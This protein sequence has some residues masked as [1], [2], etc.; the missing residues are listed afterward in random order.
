M[1]M[2]LNPTLLWLPPLQHSELPHFLEIFRGK[3][4]QKLTKG[5]SLMKALPYMQSYSFSVCFFCRIC[6]T[7]KKLSLKAKR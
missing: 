3:L 2:K 7:I 1:V 5:A 6:N 4:L